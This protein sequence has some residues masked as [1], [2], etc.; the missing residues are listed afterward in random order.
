MNF[1]KSV[2]N[3]IFCKILYKVEYINFEKIKNIKRCIICPNHSNVF[4]PTF[5]Y[6]KFDNLFIMA[7][8]ELFKNKFLK[9]LFTKYNIFPTNREKVDFKSLA[10]S[11]EIFKNNDKDVKLLMFPEGRVIKKKEDIGKYY[12]KGAV[13]I[14]ANC[15]VP[16][17]PVFITRR[18]KFFTKVKVIFGNPIYI[19]KNSI[20]SKLQVKE[21]SKKII[22]EIYNLDKFV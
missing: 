6:A 16:I 21:Q 12:R 1:M 4:D 10:Y 19:D 11:L 13:F 3:L 5:I 7:K 15:D 2:V 14:S 17:I 22:D 20:S 18:P 9:W 8:S